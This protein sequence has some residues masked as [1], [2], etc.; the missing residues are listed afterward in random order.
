MRKLVWVNTVFQLYNSDVLYETREYQAGAGLCELQ[1]LKLQI[2][3][4][5]TPNYSKSIV[6][7]RLY[8]Q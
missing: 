6:L 2:L 3:L 1:T 7:L 5:K 8:K 4:T